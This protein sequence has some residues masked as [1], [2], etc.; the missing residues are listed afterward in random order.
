MIYS[1]TTKYAIMALI[2]LASR[3]D[4]RVQIRELSESTGITHQFLG[5]IV[6]TL[7]KAGILSSTKGRGGGIQF[8][9]D[10]GMV[11]IA[12]IIRV[13]DGDQALMNCMFGLQL[14]D[15]TRNCP[16]HQLWG[17]IRE[18]IIDFLEQTTLADMARIEVGA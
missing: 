8:A 17:P 2:D 15:G 7:V 9:I 14:C 11:N 6:Q 16:I 3:S 4:Q 12:R 18:Q 10:P 1:T 5:K 13:V